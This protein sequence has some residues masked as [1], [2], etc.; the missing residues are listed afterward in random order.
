MKM[1][2][3]L[4][5]GIVLICAPALAAPM[6]IDLDEMTP[7]E[8]QELIKVVKAEYDESVEFASSDFSKLS[9]NLKQS[10]ESMFPEDA[11]VSYPFFGLDKQRARSMYRITGDCT[12]K[13]ADKSKVDYDNVTMIYWLDEANAAFEQVAF[14]CDTQ[15]F[16][17]NKDLLTI[18]TPYLDES[19]LNRLNAEQAQFFAQSV[20]ITLTPES[21]PIETPTPT[22][23][24]TEI[25]SA[26]PE[27]T[28]SPESASTFNSQSHIFD[29]AEIRDVLNGIR[30]KKLGE[31]SI[32]YAFSEDV[33]EEALNDWYYNHVAIND[34]NWCMILYL[35]AD[36]P[37]GVYGFDGFIQKNIGFIEDEYGDYSLGN[38]TSDTITY[39]PGDDGK[40]IELNFE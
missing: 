1:L 14:F 36:E 22:P 4:I 21:T 5:L 33:T 31:Y 19:L 16:Y 15:V 28:R 17:C 38:S 34:Y 7:D 6:T 37:F 11:T 24:P 8:L 30:N 29:H 3:L 27:L 20:E 40:L 26:T 2:P 23:A 18:V 32:V 10:F 35:D 39:C 25:P 13:Y 12:V 9:A